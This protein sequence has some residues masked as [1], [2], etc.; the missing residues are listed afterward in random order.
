MNHSA[1]ARRV[2]RRQAVDPVGDVGVVAGG[3]DGRGVVRLEGPDE[4]PA[5]RQPRPAEIA[6]LAARPEP[7]AGRRAACRTATSSVPPASRRQ[8]A[9]PHALAREPGG[10]R[11]ALRGD[12]VDV[13]RDLEA[14]ELQL[15]EAPSRARARRPPSSRRDAAPTGRTSSRSRRTR[16]SSSTVSEMA[17]QHRVVAGVGDRPERVAAL[18][19]PRA[20]GRVARSRRSRRRCTGRAASRGSGRSSGS[21]RPATT[22]GLSSGRKAR[23]LSRPSV[24]SGGSRDPG[25]VS[26]AAERLLGCRR[27]PGRRL[28]ERGLDASDDDVEARVERLARVQVVEMRRLVRARRLP[29][30]PAVAG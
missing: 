1:S 3:P 28:G 18:S 11:D 21:L 4:Q 12:V 9:A 19:A 24:S 13:G 10:Q 26:H 8:V 17:P 22:A 5:V 29:R 2:R 20:F 14:F 15:V 23:S 27:G 25:Q 16:S 6:G 7:G 30:R